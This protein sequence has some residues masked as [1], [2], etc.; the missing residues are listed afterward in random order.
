MKENKENKQDNKK[1][2]QVKKKRK[3]FFKNPGDED[4]LE[5]VKTEMVKF[6]KTTKVKVVIVITLAGIVS[7]GVGLYLRHERTKPLGVEEKVVV[8]APE[9][10]RGKDFRAKKVLA[11]S[12]DGSKV[13]DRGYKYLFELP[14]QISNDAFADKNKKKEE[15][16]GTEA[17]IKNEITLLSTKDPGDTSAAAASYARNGKNYKFTTDENLI[18]YGIGRDAMNYY[19]FL[20]SVEGVSP[21]GK[22]EFE[23]RFGRRF[24]DR[25]GTPFSAAT[26]ASALGI[27]GLSEFVV[28]DNSTVITQPAVYQEALQFKNYEDIVQKAQRINIESTDTNK[29]MEAWN[30]YKSLNSIYQIRFKEIE[31]GRDVTAFVLEDQNGRL[32]LYGIYYNKIYKEDQ[33][34][35]VYRQNPVQSKATLDDL[36]WD[37]FRKALK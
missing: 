15:F 34:V 10:K 18:A 25:I 31:S 30:K 17:F 8:S 11:E 26:I 23:G 20:Q 1:D 21:A 28:D 9:A 16:N 37:T 35:R 27:A 5:K 3:I 24:K 2:D 4:N 36:N 7:G 22:S 32:T 29:A 14:L 33:W 13:G 6:F 12:V 19:E